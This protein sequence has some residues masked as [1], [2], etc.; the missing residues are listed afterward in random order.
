MRAGLNDEI[1]SRLAALPGFEPPPDGWQSVLTARRRAP[2]A[3][4][5]WPMEAAAGLMAAVAGLAWLLQ[6]TQPEFAGSERSQPQAVAAARDA[7][8]AESDRLERLL[9]ALPESRA[10]RGSTAFTV[11][12]LE[13]QLVLVDDR[14]SRVALEPHAPEYAERLWRERV[15]VMNSLVQVRYADATASY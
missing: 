12:Q 15:E 13:D 10:M 5:R 1:G 11:A 2:H 14:L 7:V 4:R 8:R 3:R 9:T 6:S